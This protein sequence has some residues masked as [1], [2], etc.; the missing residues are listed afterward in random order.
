MAGKV[1]AGGGPAVERVE[2]HVTARGQA[3]HGQALGF[4]ELL[5]GDVEAM[6]RGTRRLARRQ[7]TWMRKLGGVQL[8]DVTGRDPDDVAGA[9]GRLAASPPQ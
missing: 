3:D 6:K 5:S 7:E 4:G 1:L 9:V 2:P 8:I